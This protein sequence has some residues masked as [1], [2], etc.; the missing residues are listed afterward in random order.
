MNYKVINIKCNE[1]LNTNR[2]AYAIDFLDNH[3]LKP[4]DVVITL[5]NDN[6]NSL[7]V[8]YTSEKTTNY[9][10]PVQKLF[11]GP[12]II[13]F[14][15]V[16]INEYIYNSETVF[17]VEKVKSASGHFINDRIFGF[18]IIETIF[19]HISRYEEVF[20]KD[21]QK[22]EHYR[23]RSSEQLLVRNE[24]HHTPVVDIL[25]PVFFKAL[26][27]Q[28]DDRATSFSMTHDIDAIHK[29]NSPLKLP[30]SIIRV[31][32]MGLGLNGVK[33]IIIWFFKSLIS[34]DCDPYYNFDSFLIADDVFVEKTIFFVAGGRTRFD[35]FN[36]NYLKYLPV[37][38]KKSLNKGYTIGFHPSYNAHDNADMINEE[39]SILKDM[40][41]QDIHYVRSHFL[42]VN[43]NSSFRIYENSGIAVD[44]TLGYTDDIGFRC[45]TGFKYFLYDFENEKRYKI[46][47][48]PMV[49]MDGSLLIMYCNNDSDC[50]RNNLKRFI[51][52]NKYNTHI[53]FNFHNTI[54]DR[55]LK[56]RSDIFNIYLELITDIKNL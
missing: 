28:I 25:V 46:K 9:C 52:K 53:T 36:K 43:F 29:F 47:E 32:L 24:I 41:K 1:Y 12:D 48:L 31:L 15:N 21:S 7:T 22:D 44:S 4:S 30:K 55:S 6:K 19:C 23:M 20:S 5:N 56:S 3:P 40:S 33:N 17:S 42:R 10:I 45:G 27:L 8:E 35:L 39:I 50:F 13:D 16:F 34:K 2:L 49:F 38:I 11:F 51:E 26:G 54:F 18:D 37:V 14:S